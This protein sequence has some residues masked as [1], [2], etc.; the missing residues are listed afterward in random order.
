MKKI[1]FLFSIVFVIISIIIISLI[2]GNKTQTNHSQSNPSFVAPTP[3]HAVPGGGALS[4][5]GRLNQNDKI[6]LNQQSLVSRLITT[7][8]YR[9]KAFSLEFSFNS[10]KFLLILNQKDLTAANSEFD[11]YLKQNGIQDRSWFGNNLI[12]TS[13]PFTTPPL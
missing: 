2:F 6:Q 11:N 3:F 8:P 7:L 5:V 13:E 1:M 4:G 12:I 9:G 10:G